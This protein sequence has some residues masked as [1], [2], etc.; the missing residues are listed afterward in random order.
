[1][2]LFNLL[3]TVYGVFA[4]KTIPKRTQFGPIEGVLVKSEDITIISLEDC[5][6][7]QLDLLIEMEDGEMRK[8]DVSNESK[9]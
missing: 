7:S 8:L 6:A 2:L 1:M 9:F 3:S 4:R 5:G